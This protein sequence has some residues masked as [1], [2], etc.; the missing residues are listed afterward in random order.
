MKL[1]HL[2]VVT[3]LSNV[4]SHRFDRKRL[5]QLR[6]LELEVKTNNGNNKKQKHKN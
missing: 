2:V 4:L 6:K 1:F 3:S 5:I